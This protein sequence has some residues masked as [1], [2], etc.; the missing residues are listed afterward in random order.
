MKHS[1]FSFGISI[2]TLMLVFLGSACNRIDD[3]VPITPSGTNAY[4]T[5]FKCKIDGKD[6]KSSTVTAIVANNLI[7]IG[8]E[9]ENGQSM[10]L[11]LRASNEGTYYLNNATGFSM[12]TFKQDVDLPR[13]FTTNGEAKGGGTL[14]ISKIDPARH[15]ISGS[16]KFLLVDPQTGYERDITEG[17]FTDISYQDQK[18]V[19]SMTADVDGTPWTASSI[20]IT[21]RSNKRMAVFGRS[22]EGKT[23]ELVF[24]ENIFPGPYAIATTGSYTAQYQFNF[25]YNFQSTTGNLVIGTH[26]AVNKTLQ[27]NF[28]Y[29]AHDPTSQFADISVANGAFSLVYP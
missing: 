1:I 23:V 29:T 19:G 16:F 24:P 11:S 3:S 20:L 18:N 22:S 17:F 6:W 25:L 28:S 2:L 13:V 15:K 21:K 14:T 7:M 27:G 10:M 4:T 8:G 12:A 5:P 26:D 9:T